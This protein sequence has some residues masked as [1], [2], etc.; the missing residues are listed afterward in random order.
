MALKCSAT[1]TA[2]FTSCTA[3]YARLPVPTLVLASLPPLGLP[4]PPPPE[5]EDEGDRLSCGARL[6][7]ANS[8]VGETAAGASEEAAAAAG[9]KVK[10]SG[11]G[12]K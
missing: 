1:H 11:P 2:S 3:S 5:T 8:A 4:M 10:R 6:S 12:Q 7:E 9:K